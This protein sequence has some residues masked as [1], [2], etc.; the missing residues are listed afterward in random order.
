MDEL[1]L[2][3]GKEEKWRVFVMVVCAQLGPRLDISLISRAL[4]V[5]AKSSYFRDSGGYWGRNQIGRGRLKVSLRC[6]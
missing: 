3:G 6:I 2:V 4:M 5:L 1:W